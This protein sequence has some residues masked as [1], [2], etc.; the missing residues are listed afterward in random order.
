MSKLEYAELHCHSAFSLLDGAS[1]PESLIDRAIELDLKA[2]AL[3]DHDDLGGIVRFASHAK[4][5]GNYPA[6]IGVELTLVDGDREQHLTLLSRTRDGYLNLSKLVG[7]GRA[8]ANRG[9]PGVTLQTLQS[10]YKGLLC[11]SGCPHG[12]VTQA[13]ARG[14][15][16]KA[17]RS[18][19]DLREIFGEHFAIEVMDHGLPEESLWAKELVSLACDLKLPWVVT[20]NVHYAKAAERKLH[21][22]LVCLK[23]KLTLDEA[24][25]HIRP[26]GEWYLKSAQQ[27][28]YR[29]RH[30]LD[31]LATSLQLAERC[32]FRLNDLVVPLPQLD[33]PTS[34]QCQNEYLEHL[35]LA[36][37]DIRWGL[38]MTLSHHEQLRKEFGLIRRRQLAGYFLIMNEIIQFAERSHI[39]VQ[40]RGSAANSAVCYCLGITAVDP[41]RHDLLFERFLSD[42]RDGYPDIDLDIE[43]HRREEVIQFVYERYGRNHAAMVCAHH[44]F[45]GRSAVHDT[46]R[47]LGFGVDE[48][49][50]LAAQ[51]SRE[52]GLDTVGVKA[53]GFD[54]E[55]PRIQS[56]IQIVAGLWGLP[57]HR[58]T[59]VGGFV[60]S[61]QAI[62]EF[63]PVEPAAMG[64]RTIIQWDKDDLDTLKIPKFDLLGLGMLSVLSEGLR[65][66]RL[67]HEVPA[68]LYGL[69][70]RQEVYDMI[71]RADTV[72]VF[73]IE[74]RA[75]MNSLPR[76]RPSTLYELAIQVALI[77]P[78]PL[79]GDMVH[80]YIRRKRGE[81]IIDLIHPKLAPILRRTLGVPLF[82]E[83]GMRL[84]VDAA[85]FTANESEQLRRSISSQRHRANF[86]PL[87]KK[88]RSGLRD[89][90]I[91]DDAVERIIHQIA[92][93]STYGFPE[94]HSTSFALLVY[95][96]CW[97]KCFY[98]AEFL[99][100]LVNA[101]PMGFYSVDTLIND[102]QRHGVDIRPPCLSESHWQTTI[103]GSTVRLGLHRVVGLG[104]NAMKQLQK[105]RSCGV[106][107][108]ADDVI[109]RVSLGQSSWLTLAESGAFD[110]FIPAGRRAAIWSVL[111]LSKTANDSLELE[112]S[113]ESSVQ[114]EKLTSLEETIADF[115]TLGLTTGR[116]PMLHI[117]HE[118]KMDSVLTSMELRNCKNGQWVTVGGL[119]ISRQQPETAKG[120]VFISLEDETGFVNVIVAPRAYAKSRRLI[121]KSKCLKVSGVV[122]CEQGVYNLKGIRF[123]TIDFNS[124]QYLPSG[125]NFR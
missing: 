108:S 20:N 4:E 105:A 125:Y 41:I 45:R 116:H 87:L 95:A 103:E 100:A 46:A 69:P 98:P 42:A 36:G 121:L 113:D 118:L 93:F 102:A 44:C 54:V 92:S 47:V 16:L 124:S 2:L 101:Q 55:S 25:E 18:C 62:T 68:Y 76:T 82:Q 53:A 37:A 117:R 94:S 83:Q 109:R 23:H 67:H 30:N 49:A 112:D 29:W 65:L 73:Q 86:A 90:Q 60:L 75:Q 120:F 38:S 57:R 3:T 52:K 15:Q 19:Q 59:H 17:R 114:F 122:S 79:Q 80:P 13:I 9:R 78:G 14:D 119:V 97:L 22:V 74:S 106:F 8:S 24:R 107:K 21:D 34:F 50:R 72:G 99:C 11:L 35:T 1:Q 51:V 71:A 31:G 61:T 81:E 115:K 96:S 43:H 91:P 85:G 58:G 66:V 40:G 110:R 12:A 63:C 89:N 123:E 10:H 48:G 70:D 28:A 33:L 5:R 7:I 32:E 56:L 6:I 26:N 104:Q 64:G 77:R 27:M 84:A 39:L 111:H 88:L